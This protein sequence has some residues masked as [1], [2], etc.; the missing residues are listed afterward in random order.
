MNLWPYANEFRT[1]G[2][3]G[4]LE[5]KQRKKHQLNLLCIST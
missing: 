1:T 4:G 3:I 2:M 5:F